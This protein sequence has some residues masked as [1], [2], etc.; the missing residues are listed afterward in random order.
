MTL[1]DFIEKA[2]DAIK[3]GQ[4]PDAE[5]CAWDEDIEEWAPVNRLS[6]S[7]TS[8]CIYTDED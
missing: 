6:L 5:L 4:N 2:Q 7:P 3:H 1:S 8:V